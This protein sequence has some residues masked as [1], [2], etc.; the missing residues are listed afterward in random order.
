[1]IYSVYKQM[2]CMSRLSAVFFCW[3]QRSQRLLTGWKTAE[4]AEF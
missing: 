2:L 3:Q 4:A 1:M